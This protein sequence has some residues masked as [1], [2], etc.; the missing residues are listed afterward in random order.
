[1]IKFSI[2]TAS[3]QGSSGLREDLSGKVIEAIMTHSGAQLIEFAI[4][5][6]DPEYHLDYV[7]YHV[8]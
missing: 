8:H 4:V 7:D 1:M 6:D 5:P 2:L 3:D